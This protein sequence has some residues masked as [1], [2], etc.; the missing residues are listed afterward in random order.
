MP[1]PQIAVVLYKNHAMTNENITEMVLI[2][3]EFKNLKVKN[4]IVQA[5]LINLV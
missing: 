4:S 1:N 2:L 5:D 3:I